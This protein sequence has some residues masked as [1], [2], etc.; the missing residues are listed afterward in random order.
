MISTT[1]S[2]PESNLIPLLGTK[3]NFFQNSYF[4]AAIKERNRLGLD[5][6]KSNSISII[7]KRIL[8]FIRPLPDN[9]SNS[10]YPQGLK[11]LTRLRNQ[12]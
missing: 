5:I 4:P 3:H 6:R 8:S 10:H 1:H 11:L 7:K 9:V 12:A 2:T